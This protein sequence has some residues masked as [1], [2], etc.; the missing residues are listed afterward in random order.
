MTTAQQKNVLFLVGN[1]KIGGVARPVINL[2]RVLTQRGVYVRTA[3]PGTELFPALKA[4]ASTQGIEAEAAPAGLEENQGSSPEFL[5]QLIK[6][7][8]RQKPQV[9]SLHYG[10]NY[11]PLKVLLALKMTGIPYIAS[12][13]SPHPLSILNASQVKSTRQAANLCRSVIFLS[14]WSRGQY[15]EAGLPVEKLHVI[16]PGTHPPISPPSQ[17][18]ARRTLE[19]P[20]SAFVI[21]VH[22]RLVPEKGVADVIRAVGLLSD[23]HIH[24]VIAGYG[25]ERDSLETL[26]QQ[27]LSPGH[28]HFLGQVQDPGPLYAA[29][30]VFALATQAESFGIVFVEAAFYGVP[31][32]GT[33]A[34]AVPESVLDGETGFLVAPKDPAAMARALRRLRD[35]TALRQRLGENARQRAHQN[36]QHTMRQIRYEQLLF[37]LP[38]SK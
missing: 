21:S 11:L 2:T 12:I 30:D 35:D 8:K 10:C 34:G 23:P 4:W 17:S 25:P 3:F 13:Y 33:T 15:R 29:A 32:V 27:L 31:S 28:V 7:V 22:A 5:M 36:S 18:E 26:A 38:V 20:P 37:G 1:D 19:L 16:S 9:I 24:L 14:E 6:Y